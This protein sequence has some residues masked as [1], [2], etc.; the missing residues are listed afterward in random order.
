MKFFILTGMLT[1]L[2]SLLTFA[3]PTMAQGNTFQRIAFGS[4]TNH[5][6]DVPLLKTVVATNPDLFLMI[7]DVI[8][9]D[10]HD[11]TFAPIVPWPN[12]NSLARMKQAYAQM[13][14]KPEYQYLKKHIPRMAVW[15][16]HDYGI[17]DGSADFPLKDESQQLFLDFIDEPADSERRKTPGVYDAEIVGPKNKRVQIILLDTRYFRTPPLPDTRSA[18][19][20]K[21]LNIAG[22]YAPNEDSTATLLGEAQW[23]WLKKQFQE[24]ADLRMLVSSYQLIPDEMGR[25]SWANIPHERQRLFS[26]IRNTH[27]NGIVILSGDVHFAEISMTDEGPYPLLELT[28]SAMAAPSVGYE[29]FINSHRISQTYAERNFGLVE[30][31]WDAQPA[32]QVRLKAIGVDGRTVFEHQ[33]SLE[34]LREGSE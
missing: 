31:D 5:T 15:D 19:E 12:D 10:L 8:Y 6:Q 28:S 22:R 11:E 26:L 13:T 17:N 4:C 34:E 24:T 1:I 16:D 3:P 32:P 30:I 25:D 27:A 2:V 18:E 9:P 14:T 21:A 33:I 29:K 23:R 7:G 20:K